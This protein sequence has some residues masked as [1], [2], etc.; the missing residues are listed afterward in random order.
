MKNYIVISGCSGGGKSTLLRALQSKGFETIGEAGRRIV[1]VQ[2]QTS[3]TALPWVDMRLFLEEAIV[4]ALD[5]YE[6]HSAFSETR[7]FDR[8]L[9][10]LILAY[11]HV[12]GLT[13]YDHLLTAK[14]YASRVFLTPPWP[15]IYVTDSERLHSFEDAEKEYDRLKN[16]WAS[17]GYEVVI[18][19]K[20]DVETRVDFVLQCI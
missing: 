3:G 8:G 10:D 11:S 16:G 5:D 17:L 14:P 15:D 1:K 19:P 13:S 9:V 4:L 6:K 2:I 12:T 20:A 7:F 18:I